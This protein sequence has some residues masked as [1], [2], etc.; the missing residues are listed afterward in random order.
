MRIFVRPRADNL[1]VST[2]DAHRILIAVGLCLLIVALA[3]LVLVW[4][5]QEPGSA[6]MMLAAT[7]QTFERVPILLLSILLVA[8]GGV[9]GRSVGTVRVAAALFLLTAVAVAVC[10]VLYGRA[11]LGS[12]HGVPQLLQ[13]QMKD[14]AVK[15]LF[16]TGAYVL[17]SGY[18]A[19]FL[20]RRVVRSGAGRKEIIT[21]ERSPDSTSLK[22]R[23]A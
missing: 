13:G 15:N 19:V 11:F 21:T 16:A 17:T 5:G 9:A 20:W 23:D 1:T 14:S 8:W 22:V 4:K 18:L 3:N 6:V 12:Y 2:R 10:A 7:T